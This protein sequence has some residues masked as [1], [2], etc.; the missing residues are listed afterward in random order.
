MIYFPGSI[1]TWDTFTLSHGSE[2][3]LQHISEAYDGQCD[4]CVQLQPKRSEAGRHSG[5][6]VLE[7]NL[8]CLKTVM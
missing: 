2:P 7:R 3:R 5:G 8:Q 6:V 4:G 1:L